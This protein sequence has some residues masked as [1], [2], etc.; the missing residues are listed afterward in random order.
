MKPQNEKFFY[1]GAWVQFK[2]LETEP[3]LNGQ[4]GIIC[5]EKNGVVFPVFTRDGKKMDV[6]KEN[7]QTLEVT[8]ST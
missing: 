8:S 7:L 3:D 4:A 5:G 1:V 6:K 2:D